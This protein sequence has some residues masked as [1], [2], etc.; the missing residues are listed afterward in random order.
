MSISINREDRIEERIDFTISIST[1]QFFN[2]F[3]ERAI[4]D[5]GAKIFRENSSFRRYQIPEV[6]KELVAIEQWAEENVTGSDLE[7]MKGRIKNLILKIPEGFE[8]DDT[9]LYIY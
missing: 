8:D 4:K 1:T 9:V 5:T 3:W 7:Y 6:F 2:K